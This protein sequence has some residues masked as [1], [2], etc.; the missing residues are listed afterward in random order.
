MR[1][2]DPAYLDAML[3]AARDYDLVIGSRY[4]NG[5]SVVNWPL[6]RLILSTSANPYIRALARLAPR[7]CT[8]GFRCWRRDALARVRVADCGAQGYSF[9]IELLFAADVT[10]CTITKVPIIFVERRVGASKLSWL[11][12]LESMLMPWRLLARRLWLKVTRNV[13]A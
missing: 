8:S 7:D 6:R 13:R 12:L 9:L 5:I 11:V 1:T 4:V 2:G 10:G 3:E